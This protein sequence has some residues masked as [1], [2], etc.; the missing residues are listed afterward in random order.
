MT[1]LNNGDRVTVDASRRAVYSGRLESPGS[2]SPEKKA[3]MEGSPVFN[4]LKEI[5][6]HVV[7]LNLLDPDSPQFHPKNCKTLHDITRFIH[8]KSLQEMF[9]FGKDHHF[10]ERSSK[11]LVVETPMKWWVLNLDDGFKQEVDGRYIRL[12]DIVSTPMLSLWEGISAYP[13][14]GPPPID[15]K[16]L[17]SVMF[18]ATT[19]TALNV[20]MRSRYADR[21]YFMVSRHFCNMMSRMGFHFS[22]VETIVSEKPREN[23]ISFQFTGGAADFD[24]RLRRIHFIREILETYSFIVEVKKDTLFARMQDY[25]MD[26]MGTHLKILGYLIIHTRQLDM[27]MA[28]PNSVNYYRSKIIKDIEQI[29][30]R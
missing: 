20:G 6:Q 16:G 28:N 3:L 12:D 27:I 30:E 13:W 15:G 22:T 2:D 7:P 10:P 1:R 14:E 24:R 9:N 25:D 29:V 4:T 17:M 19:N 8:E 18:Q 11:Q 5:S 26:F 23:Y 21:N